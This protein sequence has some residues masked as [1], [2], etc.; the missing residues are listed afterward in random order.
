MAEDKDKWAIILSSLSKWMQI[1]KETKIEFILEWNI[2]KVLK[3]VIYSICEAYC[4]LFLIT[5]S[6]ETPSTINN[7]HSFLQW[8]DNFYRATAVN[9]VAD[10]QEDIKAFRI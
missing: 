2:S 1:L 3:Q 10:E 4:F 6:S 8:T 5:V 7:V 9:S